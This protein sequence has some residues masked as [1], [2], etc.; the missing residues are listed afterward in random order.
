LSDVFGVDEVDVSLDL[1]EES[2]EVEDVDV[3]EEDAL[4]SL[5]AL[6]LLLPASDVD[7]L[8]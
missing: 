1:D 2:P 5:A 3:V 6:P 8:A 4:E 7:F